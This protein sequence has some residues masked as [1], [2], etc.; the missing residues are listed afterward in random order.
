MAVYCRINGVEGSVI[1]TGVGGRIITKQAVGT[2]DTLVAA[3]IAV[4]SIPLRW[5]PKVHGT[6][7][8]PHHPLLGD[9][10]R[11]SRCAPPRGAL[12]PLLSRCAL[13]AASGFLHALTRRR[14]LVGPRRGASCAALQGGGRSATARRGHLR[15]HV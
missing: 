7:Q 12:L 9:H 4:D 2:C 14:P 3:D 13:A 15:P 11:R 5:S 10:R 6:A 8:G 1:C